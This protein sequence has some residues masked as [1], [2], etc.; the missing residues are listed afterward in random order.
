MNDEQR[1]ELQ[2]VSRY[3]DRL[4][5]ARRMK[6]WEDCDKL[7]EERAREALRLHP[8]WPDVN[9]RQRPRFIDA[10]EVAAVVL[11]SALVGGASAFGL[12]KLFH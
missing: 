11:A 9:E 4:T 8:H 1:L 6:L 10:L 5:E 3:Q 12:W 7:R 2:M